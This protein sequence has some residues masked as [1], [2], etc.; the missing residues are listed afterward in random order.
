MMRR[1]TA[2]LLLL[3]SLSAFSQSVPRLLKMADDLYQSDRYLDAIEFYEKIVG[4]DKTN[5]LAR[6]RLANCYSKTLQYEKAKKTFLQLS[7]TL[8][9]EYRARS[10]Y[11]YANL[12]KQE[13]RFK[14]ADSL[15]F[16]L[17]SVPD[18]E[19][20]LVELSRKQREGCQLA[21]R[22]EKVDKGFSITEMD[23]IN[24][25]FHDFGAILNP[26]NKQVVLATTRNLPGVQYEGSQYEGLLPDLVAFENR[27]NNRWRISSSDQRF[28][29]LNTHWAEGSG[30]FTKDGQMFYFSS[31]QG[32]NG[33]ECGIMVSYLED[34][35][36]SAPV[37]LNAY[38]NEPGSE[39][40]QPAISVTGDT[41][42]FSSNRAGG[43]GGSDIWMSLKGLEKE[44][45]TPA[46]NMGAVINTPENEITP[47]YSSAFECLLFASDGHV[48]YGGYDLYAAKGESFFEPEIYNLGDPFNS[49]WDDTY[50][51]ISDTVGFLSSNRLGHEILNVYNF[52]VS[53]ERLF[54]SLLISGESLID[55]RLASRFKDI[56]S[57]DLVTFRVEDYAGYDLFEPIRPAKPK[58]KILQETD[59]EAGE[60]GEI[61]YE[62]LY[63]DY[64]VSS[65]RSEARAALESLV[66]QLGSASFES[67]NILAFTDSIGPAS[68]NLILSQNRGN[69]VKDFLVSQGIDSGKVNV[70]PRGEIPSKE[71][72]H[73]FSR[74]FKRR[75]EIIVKASTSLA[76]NKAKT[77]IVRTPGTMQDLANRL[78]VPYDDLVKW[79]GGLTGM[80]ETGNTIRVNEPT[81]AQR[82]VKQFVGEESLEMFRIPS[83]S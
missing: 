33:S 28:S 74:I 21:M 54:L 53:N 4:I 31:C 34:D 1:I 29:S 30:S 48:G 6:F 24:S 80:V 62:K 56:Q 17:I 55:A 51:A 69:A 77:Y 50:F 8:N 47:Y 19:P 67:I 2:L 65:L 78:G 43:N 46:I 66:A 44:S 64:G 32:E 70:L 13:S 22:Q 10:L 3:V 63:F 75:V 16:F 36:W 11:N 5:Q 23:G 18:A 72:D 38:I 39:N 12:L 73:W 71:G 37:P 25:D 49:T 83:G 59:L 60:V 15:Y 40:K 52:D 27:G 61:R 58:P 42:F 68:A 35:R 79:N 81:D 76:L 82:S 45:W 14:E 9:H 20:Y 7:N 57:L 41:L 26:S